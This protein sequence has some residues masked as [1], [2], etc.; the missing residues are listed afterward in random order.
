MLMVEVKILMPRT[1]PAGEII[2]MDVSEDTYMQHYAE[3]FCEWVDGVVIKKSAITLKHDDITSYL[4]GLLRA[5]LALKPVG[6]VVGAP[7]V[8]R[9]QSL[10]SCR[11]PDLQVILKANPGILHKTYMGGA[12]DICIEVISPGTES[13]DYGDKFKEYEEGGVRE[14]WI[15]DPIREECH[16]YRLTDKQLYKS[17]PINDDGYYISPLLPQFMLHVPTLWQEEL[18]TII[19]VVEAVKA[20]V[21]KA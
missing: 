14:Y 18:P 4:R 9:F 5:Y 3:N 1:L 7:F 10:K 6:R 2:A 19:E 15:I 21:E 16:F 8:M 12:A 17:Q 13:T 11:E 20:M